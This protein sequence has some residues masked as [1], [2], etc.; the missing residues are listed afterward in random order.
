MPYKLRKA[1]KRDAYWVINIETGKKH[2][3]DPLPRDRA[4]AQMRA[5]YA[6][7][8]GYEM[9]GS[10]SGIP[11]ALLQV[12]ARGAYSGRTPRAV[13][14]YELVRSS[15]TI[16]IYKKGDSIVVS[17]RGTQPTDR[18]D[19][20]ADF[21]S[22]KGT[23]A[24]TSRYKKDEAFLRK[25][26]EDYPRSKFRY[27]AVGHS[28]GGAII[29][30]FF[31][32]GLIQ[33]AFSFNPMVQPQ[34]RKGNPLHRRLYNNEDPLYLM[35][36]KDVPN[37]EVRDPSDPLW[38]AW[39]KYKLPMGLRE[40]FVA[41]DAHRLQKFKGGDIKEAI[42]KKYPPNIIA[43]ETQRVPNMVDEELPEV[44]EMN[45]PINGV[46]NPAYD[47]SVPEHLRKGIPKW[48]FPNK[49]PVKDK[50]GKPKKEKREV[51]TGKMIKTGK[52]IQKGFADVEVDVD[53]TPAVRKDLEKIEE[54][55]RTLA[56]FYG[57]RDPAASL[58]FR[59]V[60]DEIH[61]RLVPDYKGKPQNPHFEAKMKKSHAKAREFGAKA[62]L[63]DAGVYDAPTP[64]QRVNAEVAPFLPLTMT[65]E[66]DKGN[67]MYG[68]G[69]STYRTANGKLKTRYAIPPTSQYQR[70]LML[71]D[72]PNIKGKTMYIDT[73]LARVPPVDAKYAR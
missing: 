39:A 13:G 37:V 64:E 25:F 3:N 28:L 53:T 46:L 19:L 48:I 41:Y 26:Q 12:L 33:N 40:L 9:R 38:L 30:E 62:V 14:G 50:F 54:H 11:V 34:D 55:L 71:Q 35:F 10:G 23:L 1:P 17:V 16:K 61:D 65:T 68:V 67:P 45:A 6:S 70:E 31:R 52:K 63:G 24:E 56:H 8:G 27:T 18:E 4:E 32:A 59:V 60:A 58:G 43:R 20:S 22:V 47:E 7:E 36:G 66:T 44:V 69:P 5:L 51:P 15:P 72:F 73:N 29:D 42:L 2:S 57:Y 21:A 49:P